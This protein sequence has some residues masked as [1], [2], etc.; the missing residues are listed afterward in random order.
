MNF[1]NSALKQAG[2]AS[3][4]TTCFGHSYGDSIC[5]LSNVQ[6][7]SEGSTSN[8]LLVPGLCLYNDHHYTE[9]KNGTPTNVVVSECVQACAV[10]WTLCLG[11]PLP[12]FVATL[13]RSYQLVKGTRDGR[14]GMH[15]RLQFNAEGHCSCLRFLGAARRRLP[16]RDID[17]A[18]LFQSPVNDENGRR[19]NHPTTVLTA[20]RRAYLPT[21]CLSRRGKPAAL[22]LIP[23]SRRCQGFGWLP[24]R[25]HGVLLVFS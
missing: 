5:W 9:P 16:C 21:T 14:C 17:Q 11:P 12:E 2:W 15:P 13:N 3:H 25:A 23:P 22:Y 6:S 10:G 7:R 1:L 8:H 20:S 18:G 24:I 19:A 4:P